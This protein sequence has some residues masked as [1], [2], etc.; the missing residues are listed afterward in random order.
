MKIEQVFD[1]NTGERYVILYP[2]DL[3]PFDD[4]AF[5]MV[6][7]MFDFPKYV[8]LT[9]RHGD[10]GKTAIMS[11]EEC[12]ALIETIKSFLKEVDEHATI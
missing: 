5:I 7:R 12:E 10:T 6:S 4:G 8:S 3:K 2:R 9:I 11:K 1:S